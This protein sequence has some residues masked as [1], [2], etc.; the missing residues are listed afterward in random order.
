M[1]GLKESGQAVGAQAIT[2][3]ADVAAP[4]VSTRRRACSRASG[5]F[6][7]TV[8]NVPGPQLPLFMLGRRLEAFYPQVPL[9]LNTALG[10]AIMSYDGRLFFGLLGDYDAMADLD[11]VAADLDHA[12]AELARAAGVH[13]TAGAGEAAAV[14]REALAPGADRAGRRRA[15]LGGLPRAD[16][17]PRLARHERVGSASTAPGALQPD[18]GPSTSARTRRPRP[19]PRPRIRRP[20]ARTARRRSTRDAAALSD[21]QLLEA[22]HL[23]NVVIAYP[24]AQPPAALRTLQRDGGRRVQP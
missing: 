19:P 11:A 15:G 23:G 3:L 18:H 4:T 14:A 20:V 12:I 9:V 8:T 13:R 21:D 24:D 7:L 10:I 1:A 6:N 17:H 22:L 5:F 2:R 16:L